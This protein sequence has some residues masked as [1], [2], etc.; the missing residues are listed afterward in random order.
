[1]F[2]LAVSCCNA[3]E[4]IH[5]APIS[6]RW[7]SWRKVLNALCII[8][9]T[10]SETAWINEQNR[11]SATMNVKNCASSG[12]QTWLQILWWDVT[13]C[14]DNICSIVFDLNHRDIRAKSIARKCSWYIDDMTSCNG[15]SSGRIVGLW[16]SPSW[17]S[18]PKGTSRFSTTEHLRRARN[19]TLVSELAVDWAIFVRQFLISADAVVR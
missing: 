15:W 14:S 10:E 5:A 2:R 16:E 11:D 19:D 18:Y 4:K 17:A 12:I 13:C 8:Y 6:S 7:S 3:I 9:M 1:M